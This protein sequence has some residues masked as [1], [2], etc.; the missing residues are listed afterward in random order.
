MADKRQKS[1]QGRQGMVNSN[2]YADERE[3][4]RLG[5][6]ITMLQA[7]FLAPYVDVIV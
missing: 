1:M 6:A 7:G 2:A 5:R 3:A 4:Y